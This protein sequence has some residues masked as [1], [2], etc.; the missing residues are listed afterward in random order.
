MDIAVI[1]ERISQLERAQNEIKQH[2]TVLEDAL[3]EDERFQEVDLQMRELATK[4]KRIKDEIWGQ[5]AYVEAVDKIKDIKEEI[6]D[7]SEILN[8]ELLAWR[9]QNQSDEI[10]GSDGTPRKLKINVRLQH[11]SSK[12]EG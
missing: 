12:L 1:Q 6:A 9:E 3:K 7:L 11:V 5:A 8:H 4:K 2:K 10:V